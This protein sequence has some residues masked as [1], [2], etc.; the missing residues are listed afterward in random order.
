M[1]KHRDD[2]N[3]PE[4]RYRP[5]SYFDPEDEELEGELE[6]RLE[7][8]D[9]SKVLAGAG[10]LVGILCVVGAV[11]LVFEGLEESQEQQAAAEAP[12]TDGVPADLA[13]SQ[14]VQDTKAELEALQRQ[15][16]D[17]EAELAAAE[18]HLEALRADSNSRAGE[19][20]AMDA[21]AE[22]LR[23]QVAIL[24]EQLGQ[25]KT[26]RDQ[27]RQRLVAALD[28]LEGSQEELAELTVKSAAWKRTSADNLWFA[29]VKDTQLQVCTRGTK[30]ARERCQDTVKTFF[31]AS[32]HERFVSCVNTAQAVPQL[33]QVEDQADL[34]DW[35]TPLPGDNRQTRKGWAVTWCDPT[36]PEAVADASSDDL[37]SPEDLASPEVFAVLE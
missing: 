26:E 27:L 37:I 33:L 1:S 2:R 3:P 15:L 16:T 32:A 30:K 29:F 6:D 23:T 21:K 8:P 10:I 4:D 25:A 35:S 9:N 7:L 19:L 17:R 5:G 11:G 22:Q 34:P 12:L 13:L 24:S 31:D 28:E 18:A 14:E 36:L 20:A